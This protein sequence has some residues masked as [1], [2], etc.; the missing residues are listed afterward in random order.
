[1]GAYD[2]EAD[3]GAA[4]DGFADHRDRLR[5]RHFRF[6]QEPR[7]DPEDEEYWSNLRCI[8]YVRAWEA[9]QRRKGLL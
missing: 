1:M 7:L 8:R 4:S 2:S 3:Q 5:A 6:E 9:E